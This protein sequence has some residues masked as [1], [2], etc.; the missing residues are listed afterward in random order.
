MGTR[1]LGAGPL[2]SI[3]GAVDGKDCP[4]TGDVL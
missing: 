1:S 2:R 4:M 3:L